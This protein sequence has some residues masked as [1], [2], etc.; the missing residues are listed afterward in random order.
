MK[1]SRSYIPKYTV[2]S[3]SGYNEIVLC[4]NCALYHVHYEIL[5]IDLTL[6]GLFSLKEDLESKILAYNGNVPNDHRCILI[7][8]LQ[9]NLRL[10]FSLDDCRILTGMIVE[11]INEIRNQPRKS[12]WN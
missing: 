8:S 1:I 6:K 3:K 7:V 10:Y 12:K 2:L 9:D 4:G 5:S 11:S